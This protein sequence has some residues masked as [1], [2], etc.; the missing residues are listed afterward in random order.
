M[1]ALPGNETHVTFRRLHAN[2][3]ASVKPVPDYIRSD[4]VSEFTA[5]TVHS[6]LDRVDAKALF[7]IPGS[8]CENG[9]I[10]TFNGTL[11]DGHLNGELFAILLETR[12]LIERW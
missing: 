5:R 11:C 12:L 7:I 10:E 9:Y 6:G 1:N 2:K 4:N 3:R 8:P